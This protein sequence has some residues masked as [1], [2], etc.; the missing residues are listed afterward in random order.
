MCGLQFASVPLLPAPLLYSL[1]CPDQLPAAHA[2]LAVPGT[3]RSNQE[4]LEVP[5]ELVAL[6]AALKEVVNSAA[7]QVR[8][9]APTCLVWAWS[10][11]G[12]AVDR[13]CC[14]L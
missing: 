6:E 3:L 9:I 10:W 11:A 7:I 12:G 4:I 5:F 13:T 2:A 8:G 1:I 14:G